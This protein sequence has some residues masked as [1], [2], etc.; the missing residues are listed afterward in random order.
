VSA[1]LKIVAEQ[2]KLVSELR[3]RLAKARSDYAHVRA[4]CGQTGYDIT[5]SGVRIAVACMDSRTYMAKMIRGR[6]M[7][8]LGA[9]KTL[10]AVIDSAAENLRT[11]E[12]KLAELAAGDVA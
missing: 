5:I 4:L 9:L 12:L 7:L 10:D 11:E 6:E 8:H 1:D 3:V 2:V